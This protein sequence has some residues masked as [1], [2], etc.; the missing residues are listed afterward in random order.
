MFKS[1]IA[2]LMLSVA[3]PDCA[4]I[5]ESHA[6]LENAYLAGQLVHAEEMTSALLRCDDIDPGDELR[7]RLRLFKIHDRVGL[8]TN[9]RPVKKAK[10]ALDS[11]E[12]LRAKLSAK[13]KGLLTLGWAEYY[14]RAEMQ[15]RSF[16]KASKYAVEAEQIF[17]ALHDKH[18]QADAVHRQGL[19][20]FQQR[21]IDG[22][23]AL[24]EARQLFDRSLALDLAGGARLIF[25]GDYNRHIG[26]IENE[27]GNEPA[28]LA[29]FEK[30]LECRRQAGAMDQAMFALQSLASTKLR[31][32]DAQ[33]S[34][35]LLLEALLIA[36]RIPSPMMRM[37]V[38]KSAGDTYLVM[39]KIAAAC[40]A[41]ETSLSASLELSS[42]F[43]ADTAQGLLSEHCEGSARKQRVP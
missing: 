17:D 15:Q 35:N 9:S 18:G 10:K 13:D 19:I 32:G 24:T 8:H 23:N 33:G 39:G 25:C 2:A 14:Y 30:S 4:Y 29:H 21:R 3:A 28:V 41:Y 26:F 43:F 11:A 42:V 34:L 1:E 16:S 20:R 27:Y 31:G 37:Q 5:S 22:D 7:L 36:E 40:T 6:V 12:S 38:A